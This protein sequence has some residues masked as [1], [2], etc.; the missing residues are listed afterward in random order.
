MAVYLWAGAAVFAVTLTVTRVVTERKVGRAMVGLTAAVVIVAACAN[1]VNAIYGAY[2]TP[3][4]ALHMVHP[5]DIALRDAPSDPAAARRRSGGVAVVP[6]T[7]INVA[8]QTHIRAD[9][10][11]AVRLHRA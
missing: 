2:V 3:R 1:Q 7:G 8:G 10:G 5:D 4:D 11:T 6:A 9:R